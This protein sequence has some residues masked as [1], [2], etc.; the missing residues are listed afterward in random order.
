[1]AKRPLSVRDLPGVVPVGITRAATV[2]LGP[3]ESDGGADG[4]ERGVRSYA[5]GVGGSCSGPEPHLRGRSDRRCDRPVQGSSRCRLLVP[6]GAQQ[7]P[8]GPGERARGDGRGGAAA[9]SRHALEP[10]VGSVEGGAGA[11]RVRPRAHGPRPRSA[12]A[13]RRR[14]PPRRA[15]RGGARAEAAAARRPRGVP[16]G[17]GARLCRHRQRAVAALE[18]R[19]PQLGRGVDE[20]L[21]AVLRA[22]PLPARR[23]GPP[24]LCGALAARAKRKLA[25][26][27]HSAHRSPAVQCTA[28]H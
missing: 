1:M 3:M 23:V 24:G 15:R 16:R 20:R 13:R 5:A 12:H 28:Q 17:R 25:R 19:R 22:P 7:G 14:L 10:F 4:G 11:L 9:A 21:R 8:I 18:L 26:A 2:C 27:T 6:R